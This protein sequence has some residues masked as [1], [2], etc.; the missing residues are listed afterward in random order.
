MAEARAAGFDHVN[1]D[2]IYGTPGES[3]EDWRASLAAAVG[4]GPTTSRRTR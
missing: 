2:L 1:L 3:D 4:R